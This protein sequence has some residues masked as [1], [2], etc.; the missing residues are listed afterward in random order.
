MCKDTTPIRNTLHG[1]IISPDY[2][3]PMADNSKCSLTIGMI[4]IR[5]VLIAKFYLL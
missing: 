2:P 1:Y 3:H 4:L 5:K